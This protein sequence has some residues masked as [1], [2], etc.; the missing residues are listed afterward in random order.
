M[1]YPSFERAKV[2]AGTRSIVLFRKNKNSPNILRPFEVL[3][4]NMSNI[5]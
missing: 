2:V 3:A 4:H 1:V 5:G